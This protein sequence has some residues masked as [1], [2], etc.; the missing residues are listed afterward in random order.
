MARRTS[1]SILVPLLLALCTSASA[2]AAD[3]PGGA[4]AFEAEL[5]DLAKRSRK[6][7]VL[8]FGLI[9]LGSGAVVDH[10]GTVVTNAHVCAGARYAVIQWADGRSVLA[11]RQGIDYAA[12][13]AILKPVD[14]LKE[15][16]PAFSLAPSAPVKGQW[17]M[18]AGF[19]GGL[20]TTSE[21]T[22]S[23]GRVL[24]IGGGPET[25]IAFLDYSDAIRSDMAIFSGNSGGPMFDL[26]GRLLGINGAVDLENAITLT[27][28]IDVV[29]ARLRSLKDGLI[30]LPGNQTLRPKSNPILRALFRAT[31]SLAR[32]MPGRVADGSRQA[33]KVGKQAAKRAAPLLPS[34]SGSDG[35]STV[36]R[37]LP[38]QAL[39]DKAFAQARGLRTADGL[40]LTPV[41]TRHAVAKASLLKG[42]TRLTGVNGGAAELLAT[43]V[44]DDLALL[45]LANPLKRSRVDA[46]HRPVGSLICASGPDGI[47]ASGMLSAPARPTSATLLASIQ[48]GGNPM[49]P[50]LK[51]FERLAKAVRVKAIQ[52]LLDQIK[53]SGESKN[54]FASGTPP[55][56]YRE[57][58]SV[59]A[60]IAPSQM[61]APVF[62]R[63]GHVIGVAIGIAH[64]GTTYVVPMTRVRSVFAEHL[65]TQTRPTRLGKAK[66]Y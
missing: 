59:D 30:V 57:V 24:G 17:V 62:D 58:L 12:D 35:L 10:K 33:A 19:P 45:V 49:D 27:I 3:F 6:R 25:P 53:K 4:D 32:Q 26:Q 64:H 39:L 13:L 37:R 47:L 22:T 38:R 15:S 60:P 55:R 8:V 18:G 29:K 1:T 14:P 9:G 44:A 7:T 63:Q 23:L 41:G 40:F 2:S 51:I 36:A 56:S 21:P 65:G 28:P 16:V 48:G 31:D 20:R 66:L 54:K 50:I 52:D 5:K 46:P 43:S 34:S 42:K 61:G 11:E